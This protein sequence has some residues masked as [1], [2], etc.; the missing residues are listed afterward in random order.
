MLSSSDITMLFLSPISD[1]EAL[2]VF[3]VGILDSEYVVESA[4]V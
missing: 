4:S 3:S 2:L 1:V